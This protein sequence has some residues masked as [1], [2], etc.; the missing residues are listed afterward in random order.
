MTHNIFVYGTLKRGHCLANV[1]EDQHFL[2][3]AVTT[4]EYALVNLGE[5]PGLVMPSVFADQDLQGRSVQGELYRVDLACLKILDGVECVDQGMYSRQ[6][7]NLVSP[8]SLDAIA[9]FYQLPVQ[10]SQIVNAWP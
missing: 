5:Y 8:D 9:Y 4:P 3:E 10:P 2:G 7:V 6:K 1:L